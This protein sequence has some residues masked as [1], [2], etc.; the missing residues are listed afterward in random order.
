MEK[1]ILTQEDLLQ[2]DAIEAEQCVTQNCST[3]SDNDSDNFLAHLRIENVFEYYLRLRQKMRISS[4]P[5]N[6]T[7]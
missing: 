6:Q 1:D 5:Q 2:I 7:R 4:Y 3:D